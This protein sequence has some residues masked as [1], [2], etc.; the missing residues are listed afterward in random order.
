[1]AKRAT[2]FILSAMLPLMAGCGHPSIDAAQPMSAPRNSGGT[3]SAEVTYRPNV[4]VVEQSDGFNA[5]VSVSTDGSTLVFDRRLGKIPDMKDGDVLLIK[6]LLARKIITSMTDGDELAV[7]TAPAGLLDIVSDAKIRLH[8]PIRFG[9][10]QAIAAATPSSSPWHAFVDAVVPP[11]YAQSPVEERRKAAIDKGRQDAYGN[12]VKAPFKAV[13]S[14]WD[15]Q[16]S[17]EPAPGRLNLSLQMKK[18]VSGV[19]AVVTGDGYLAD[20]DFDAGIDV[21]RS[22]VEKMQL[23]YKKLNGLMNFKWD[24]QTTE[25]GTLRGN[26]RMKLP[27]AIEIPLY[28]YLGGLPLYLEISSAVII[29]P[30]LGAQYEFSHGAFRITY[31][32][33]QSFSA[34]EGVADAD[35]NVTG[36]IQLIDSDNGSGAPIGMVVAFAAPR[37]EL[38]IGVGKVFKFDGVKD[39]AKK[40]DEYF[41]LLVTKAFGADALA[42]FRSSPLSEITATKIVDTALG[43]DAAA[44]IELVTTNGMSHTGNL[45]MVPCTRND[46]HMAVNVGASAEAFGQSVGNAEKEIF[47]KDVTRVFPS[48]NALCNDI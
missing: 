31:D 39:A 33:Y 36:D 27:A 20:F 44:Y 19:V 45:A 37:V 23:T 8:A 16:F 3:G 24:V 25:N 1:M 21:E 12:L 2:P 6:G 4:R 10:A 14:G 29:N 13:M 46:L 41:A 47:K 35:G 28:Q 7:L 48:G 42:K 30:A 34:K 18:S 40:A 17:A 5:L 26:A 9:T 38:S 15:T 32:G 43:S 11:A 22:T